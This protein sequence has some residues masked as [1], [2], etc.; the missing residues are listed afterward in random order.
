MSHYF[1]EQQQYESE[2]R[3]TYS[4]HAEHN[5]NGSHVVFAE[6]PTIS[7]WGTKSFNS[8]DYTVNAMKNSRFINMDLLPRSIFF[9]KSWY[10][11]KKITNFDRSKLLYYAVNNAIQLI[12]NIAG[13]PSFFTGK[14]KPSVKP[15]IFPIH[16]SKKV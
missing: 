12:I 15:E 6:S 1:S 16:R 9:N 5:L 4:A 3:S 2:P 10:D 8:I 11:F 7:E 13:Y 14:S